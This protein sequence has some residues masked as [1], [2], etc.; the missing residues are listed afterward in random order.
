M[1]KIVIITGGSSGI[2]LET[3]KCLV[4]A[5][6]RVYELSRRKAEFDFM[7]HL[8]VDIADS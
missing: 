4:A 2:G 1:E 5:G 8:S 7:Q 6:C 3:A